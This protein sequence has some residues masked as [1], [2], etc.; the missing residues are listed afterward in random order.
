MLLDFIVGVRSSHW[1]T[2]VIVRNVSKVEFQGEKPRILS[3]ALNDR[4]RE[5]ERNGNG[6]F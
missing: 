4:Q 5:R 6:K 1:N 3:V 2:T